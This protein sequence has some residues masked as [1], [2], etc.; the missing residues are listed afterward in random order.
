MIDKQKLTEAVNEAIA[1]TGLFL[2]NLNV[3]PDDVITVTVDSPDGVDIDQCVSLTRAIEARFDRDDED[4]EL[5]VGSAGLTAPWTVPQQYHMNVGNPVEVVTR[6][7][8]KLRGTLTAVSPDFTTI[9]V[10]VPT[11]VKPEGAKRPHIEDVPTQINIDDIKSI[12]RELV[13]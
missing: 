5:E 13:F 8:A 11:K 6:Q 12:V 3:T 10:A 2:V 7:G 9:T 1:G 4:Y